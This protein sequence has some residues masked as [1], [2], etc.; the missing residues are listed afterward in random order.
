MF[1]KVC[2]N[3]IVADDGAGQVE[4]AGGAVQGH[5]QAVGHVM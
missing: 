4:H 3:G 1:A 2:G 5:G